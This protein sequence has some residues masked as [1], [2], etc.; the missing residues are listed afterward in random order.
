MI[1][2][3][4]SWGNYHLYHFEIGSK[5]DMKRITPQMDSFFEL[6]SF[7][8]DAKVTYLK[9][10]LKKGKK[11]TYVYDMGDY[12][13]HQIK[14]CQHIKSYEGELPYLLSAEGV[15]P[16]EDCGGSWGFEEMLEILADKNHDRY[17]EMVEWLGRE[18]WRSELYSFETK[19][20]SLK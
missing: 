20:K 2:K 5:K 6:K 16:P 9:D 14:V 18:D 19:P 10:F 1:Q 7:E 3:A 4:F 12:W 15:T 13:K 8:V 17:F 11:L